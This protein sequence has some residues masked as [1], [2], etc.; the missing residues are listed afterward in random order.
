MQEYIKRYGGSLEDFEVIWEMPDY[1]DDPATYQYPT[2]LNERYAEF[3]KFAREFA[4]R[5]INVDDKLDPTV[6][7][8]AF[9][10]G[11]VILDGTPA[12]EPVKEIELHYFTPEGRKNCHGA[13]S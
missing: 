8:D 10:L 5:E 7:L 13:G 4:G 3:R 2:D 9:L 11:K 1:V 12:V 6:R